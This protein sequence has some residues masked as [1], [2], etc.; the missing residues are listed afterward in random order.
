MFGPCQASQE[1][2]QS[3]KLVCLLSTLRPAP[4]IAPW[5]CDVEA[6]YIWNVS[7]E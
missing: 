3:M 6:P 1:M 2:L 4:L 5:G 7:T